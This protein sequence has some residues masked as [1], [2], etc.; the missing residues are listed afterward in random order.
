LS[1]TQTQNIIL[2]LIGLI[3]IAGGLS[4][5]RNYTGFLAQALSY[6]AILVGAVFF[7]LSISK[8]LK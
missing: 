6:I 3:L 4:S 1:K 5:V 8:F 2:F 7:Y